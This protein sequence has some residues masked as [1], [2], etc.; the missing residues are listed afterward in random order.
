MIFSQWFE[1][2][3]PSIALR[4]TFEGRSRIVH[5]FEQRI[6]QSVLGFISDITRLKIFN[7]LLVSEGYDITDIAERLSLIHI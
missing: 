5:Y 1:L 7:E 6:S 3:V 4:L 2:C